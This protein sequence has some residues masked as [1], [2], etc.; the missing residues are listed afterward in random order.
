M[1]EKIDINNPTYKLQPLNF[2]DLLTLTK[3]IMNTT[4]YRDILLLAND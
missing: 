2:F 1:I 4:E 3:N